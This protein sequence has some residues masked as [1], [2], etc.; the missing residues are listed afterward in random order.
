MMIM[1]DPRRH[2][3]VH[4]GDIS[5]MK[6]TL[7]QAGQ[8]EVL[9]IYLSSGHELLVREYFGSKSRLDLRHAHQQLMEACK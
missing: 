7:E 1:V 5:A 6:I 3:A 4:P 9:V 8:G 2:I